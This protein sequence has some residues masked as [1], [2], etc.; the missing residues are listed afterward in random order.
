MSKLIEP[1]SWLDW[2]TFG[3]VCFVI[4]SL[5]GAGI[6]I[7]LNRNYPPLRQR[8][9]P[10][11]I[12]V[13]ISG[14]I[15]TFAAIIV[16]NHFPWLSFL[17]HKN[18]VFWN[19]W[20]QYFVGLGIWFSA[21][22]LR[23]VTYGS[24]F[25]A[26]V[27]DVGVKRL[28]KLKYL[29]ILFFEGPLLVIL[30]RFTRAKSSYFDNSLDICTSGFEFKLSLLLW[31]LFA[32]GSLMAI[33]WIVHKAVVRDHF[34]EVNM[35]WQIIIVGLLIIVLNGNIILFDLMNYKVARFIVTCNIGTLHLFTVCRLSLFRIYKCIT[36]DTSY[37]RKFS[38]MQREYLIPISN[39]SDMQDDP[40]K[41]EITSAFLAYCRTQP[42]LKINDFKVD[43]NSLVDAYMELSLWKSGFSSA[44]PKRNNSRYTV[45]CDRFIL[46]RS[47]QYIPMPENIKHFI[48][49]TEKHKE[50]FDRFFDYVW[51][52]LDMN[53]A[54]SY[55]NS[56][57][58]KFSYKDK[59][60]SEYFTH[61]ERAK[62]SDR[63]RRADLIEPQSSLN[64]GGLDPS[65]KSRCKELDTFNES[66][67]FDH[68]Q[69][70]SNEDLSSGEE[71][72]YT[73]LDQFTDGPQNYSSL[74]EFREL[75]GGKE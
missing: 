63:L 75:Q 37:L 53:F 13:V 17:E 50:M 44:K 21:I 57:E 11:L 66:I 54:Y 39:F 41:E 23:L 8:N 73:D 18:C 56:D 47:N 20:L 67:D 32:T 62:A 33:L 25:M 59:D 5:G 26:N 15:H 64:N 72:A 27:S 70:E 19:Y 51:E 48:F 49:Q 74:S 60:Y 31:V 46:C 1:V 28:Q 24:I 10:G 34:Y 3:Y 30:I 16:N 40:I 2:L 22:A 14:I 58:F 38:L 69:N 4:L 43:P 6:F 68:F 12:A 45:I 65:E 35:L 42:I 52:T 71:V 55:L 29:L 7:Y 61:S 9:V 36:R